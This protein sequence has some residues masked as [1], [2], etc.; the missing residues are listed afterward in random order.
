MDIKGGLQTLCTGDLPGVETPGK[1]SE[2]ADMAGF[3]GD[4]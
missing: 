1:E 2:L 4:A 3:F